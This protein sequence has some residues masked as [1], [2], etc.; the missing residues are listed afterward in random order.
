MDNLTY[1][2]FTI[3]IYYAFANTII[4]VVLFYGVDMNRNR[5]KMGT[6]PILELNGNHN[7]NH[8]I[9]DACE[10]TLTRMPLLSP[11]FHRERIH[12]HIHDP[13][14]SDKYRS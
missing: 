5:I 10:L 14:D 1:G 8:I 9:N 12:P 4:I 7:H 2:S 3:T 6:K 13:S 11:P